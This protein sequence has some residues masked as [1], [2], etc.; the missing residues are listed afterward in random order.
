MYI[1]Q[2]QN[3]FVKNDSV[4]ESIQQGYCFGSLIFHHFPYGSSIQSASAIQQ[5]QVTSECDR[6]HPVWNAAW[7]LQLTCHANSKGSSIILEVFVQCFKDTL[8][9]GLAHSTVHNH[10]R[11]LSVKVQSGALMF[12]GEFHISY[13]NTT[14]RY[15][16]RQECIYPTF[17]GESLK[18]AMEPL[19]LSWKASWWFSIESVITESHENSAHNLQG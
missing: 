14:R 5:C 6:I 16:D 3:L 1:R 2:W 4:S 15:T 9:G 12:T 8:S 10:L 11:Q 13:L 19:A 7:C 18:I 17:R